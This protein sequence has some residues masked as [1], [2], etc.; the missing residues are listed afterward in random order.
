[1]SQPMRVFG[2]KSPQFIVYCQ[3]WKLKMSQSFGPYALQ[4]PS[5]TGLPLGYTNIV[6]MYKIRLRKR[7]PRKSKYGV[8]VASSVTSFHFTLKGKK[9]KR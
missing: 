2:T 8:E 7:R 4:T 6:S 1:M 9:Q 3:C 5:V